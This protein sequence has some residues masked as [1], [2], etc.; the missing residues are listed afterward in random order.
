MAQDF[1]LLR[2]ISGC[3]DYLM[4]ENFERMWCW[5]YP[6]ALTL[7]RDSVKAMWHSVSPRW[8]EGFITKEEAETSLR[9]PKGHQE[10]GTFVLRFP[11]SRSWPH[12][13]AGC[14][15]VTYMGND[16]SL[17]HKLLSFDYICRFVPLSI[18]CFIFWTSNINLQF[19]F[20][21]SPMF[22]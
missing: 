14:L 20:T 17:R 15:V 2:R 9:S 18:S 22:L 19:S 21:H 1:E 16:Y 5:L 4:Q 8:I 7:L 13:D 6:V 11:T 10:P 12:P 3:Q